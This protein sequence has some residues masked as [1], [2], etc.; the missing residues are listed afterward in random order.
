MIISSYFFKCFFASLHLTILR[1]IPS[2][3][4]TGTIYINTIERIPRSKSNGNIQIKISSPLLYSGLSSLP[5]RQSKV[6]E[7]H[8]FHA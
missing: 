6:A 1:I 2:N 7:F 4:N 5:F 3:N 8:I